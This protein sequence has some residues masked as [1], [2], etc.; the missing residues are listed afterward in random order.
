MLNKTET[1]P[2]LTEYQQVVRIAVYTNFNC[3]DAEYKQV[4]EYKEKYPDKF[5]FVNCNV[6]T[7]RL[8]TLNNHK[9]KVVVTVN[10]D[11]VVSEEHLCRFYEI[12]P[13][14][15]AFARVKYLPENPSITGLITEL[16]KDNYN[17]VIT[18][19]RFQRKNTLLHYTDP[20]HYEYDCSRF[21]LNG[22]ALSKLYALVDAYDPP[23]VYICDR[24][25]LGCSACEL[26]SL[27]T[28]GQKLQ[29]ASLDL[30]TSGQCP[31]SCPDCYAK[32]LQVRIKHIKFDAIKRNDK[33]TGQTVHIKRALQV[34]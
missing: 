34:A 13:E 25:G 1:A 18:P 2:Q 31:Y 20:K 23:T 9:H 28:T 33:Q 30:S 15:V 11:L 26:C 12:H 7:P 8:I 14:L 21:R 29:I 32:A 19:Q 24:R 17:V 5:F 3:T 4:E 10:P 27:L 16:H 22:E 6:R